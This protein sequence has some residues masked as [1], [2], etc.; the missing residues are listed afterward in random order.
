MEPNHRIS[1]VEAFNIKE[2]WYYIKNVEK[3]EQSVPVRCI[4][5]DN[6][7]SLY[8]AGNTYI[9]THNTT[10]TTIYALWMT[11]FDEFKRVVIVANKET[12]AIM[13]LRRVA[14]AYEELPNWLKPG[15]AQYGK[16]EIIFANHSSVS[17]STTTGSAVRGD[18]VNCIDGNTIVTVKNKHTGQIYDLTM[19]D[20][21]S[22]IAKDGKILD[23]EIKE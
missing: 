10:L 16:K 12:T 7:D 20:L 6:K 11:C 2:L 18:T 17:I 23:C 5:V 13:I 1:T 21:S 9:K 8:L 15:T 3:L 14:L 22:I 4:T 19:R